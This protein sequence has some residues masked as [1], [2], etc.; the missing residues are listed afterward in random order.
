[1]RA[2]CLQCLVDCCD[3]GEPVGL[4]LAVGEL[5]ILVSH[6]L[7]HLAVGLVDFVDVAGRHVGLVGA[8]GGFIGLFVALLVTAR[9]PLVGG[10][11]LVLGRELDDVLRDDAKLGV[12]AEHDFLQPPQARAGDLSELCLLELARRHA[13]RGVADPLPEC[14]KSLPACAHEL[15]GAVN[16]ATETVIEVG[17]SI[18]PPSVGG[19]LGP[20]RRRGSAGPD[21]IRRR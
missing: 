21:C 3:V 12:G 18:E 2:R 20:V 1:M 15:G 6:L 17:Q 19:V 4:D 11:Q 5:L 10:H 8:V 7:Q 13:C 16:A 9:S 14:V